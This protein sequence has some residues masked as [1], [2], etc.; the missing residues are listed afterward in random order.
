MP[1]LPLAE[2]PTIRSWAALCRTGLTIEPSVASLPDAPAGAASRKDETIMILSR[3]SR[4]SISRRADRL[5]A[6]TIAVA[7]GSGAVTQAGTNQVIDL[8]DI[9]PQA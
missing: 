6:S 5:G 9:D 2:A 1:V 3:N 7:P 8:N 4:K